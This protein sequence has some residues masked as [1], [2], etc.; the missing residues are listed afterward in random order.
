[1]IDRDDE[2][3]DLYEQVFIDLLELMRK[4]EAALEAG[5]HVQSVAKY[6]ER[7]AD[8]CT[9]VAEQVIYMLKGQDVRHHGKLGGQEEAQGRR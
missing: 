3:D 1:V 5:I 4:D 7:M 2:V 6:L 9:N 8:H